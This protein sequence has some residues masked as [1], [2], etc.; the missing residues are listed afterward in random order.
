MIDNN[1]KQTAKER[2]IFF[3]NLSTTGLKE[4]AITYDAKNNIKTFVILDIKSNTAPNKINK[5]MFFT[6]IFSFKT[7]SAIIIP[8]E[9]NY[10][11]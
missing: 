8:P 7:D 11:K 9:E 2:G 3:S 10:N 6:V 5:I 1:S 4:Q